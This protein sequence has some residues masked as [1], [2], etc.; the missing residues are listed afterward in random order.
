[1]Q[2]L[3]LDIESRKGTSAIRPAF[4]QIDG[5]NIRYARA[6]RPG[7]ETIL[8]TSSWSESQYAYLPVWERL[9]TRDEVI[10]IDLP[11]FRLVK[12]IEIGDIR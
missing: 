5:L 4:A 6:P 3:T 2:T 7:A 1:M 8:L 11:G 12:R 9:A 10:A